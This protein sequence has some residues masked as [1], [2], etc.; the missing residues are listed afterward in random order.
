MNNPVFLSLNAAGAVFNVDSLVVAAQVGQLPVAYAIV[1]PRDGVASLDSVATSTPLRL[2][3]NGGGPAFGGT[4]W[5]VQSI[6]SLARPQATPSY[7]LRLGVVPGQFLP[8]KGHAAD[9]KTMSVVLGEIGARYLGQPALEHRM[10]GD[11]PK[12]GAVLSYGESFEQ[13]LQRMAW[14]SEQWFCARGEAGALQLTWAA[15]LQLLGM[16]DDE[17]RWA[18]A[19]VASERFIAPTATRSFWPR[20]LVT[21]RPSPATAADLHT[22]E[23]TTPWPKAAASYEQTDVAD[24]P[25]QAAYYLS[26]SITHVDAWPGV[27]VTGDETIVAAIH[28]YHQAGAGEVRRLLGALVPGMRHGEQLAT[29]SDSAAYGVAAVAASGASRHAAASGHVE[30][31]RWLAQAR[32]IAQALGLPALDE[33]AGTTPPPATL[34][35][36]VAPWGGDEPSARAAGD[37]DGQERHTAEIKVCFDWSEIPVR[38]PFAYPMSGRDGIFYCPPAAGDRVLVHLERL[39]PVVASSAY[40]CADMPL[41]GVLWHGGDIDS[42]SAPRGW[43]VRGGMIFRTAAEGDLVIHAAGNLV[44]RAEKDIFIDGAHLHDHGRAR[45]G[46]DD[47]VTGAIHEISQNKL[48]GEIS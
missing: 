43:V 19:R 34:L 16:A 35:A 26:D 11:D 24:C 12:L 14:A 23:R 39:W 10:Q 47:A 45:N 7:S 1:T 17:A 22:T 32:N 38:L 33:S 36:T 21:N 25:W 29:L 41:P 31:L 40:Q 13:F 44:L 5:Y 37:I 48:N 20:S 8:L 4:D 9:N 42:L 27:Q 46:S 30:R 6:A 2:S 3:V 28:V 18:N 15:Q